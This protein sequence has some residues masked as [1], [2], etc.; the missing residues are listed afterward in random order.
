MPTIEMIEIIM[1]EIII[2][3]SF[4]NIQPP[5]LSMNLAMPLF[6]G[7]TSSRI[8]SFFTGRYESTE[9]TNVSATIIAKNIPKLENRPNSAIIVK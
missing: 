9:G 7:A 1:A 3:F 8:V 2:I 5:I 6:L 4:F